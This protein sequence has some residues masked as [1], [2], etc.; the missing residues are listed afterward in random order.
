MY[1][2]LL[3]SDGVGLLAPVPHTGRRLK[4]PLPRHISKFLGH[5]RHPL[6]AVSALFSREQSRATD[7]R[8]LESQAS[9]A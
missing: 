5:C 4:A 6:I 1:L 2:Q 9:P 8:N 3:E 7:Y